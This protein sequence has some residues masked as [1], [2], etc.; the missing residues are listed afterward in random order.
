[1]K[2]RILVIGTVGVDLQMGFDFLPGG[3]Q[4]VLGTRFRFLPGGKG[5]VTSVA[6]SRLGDESLICTRVGRDMNASR[7]RTVFSEEGIDDRFLISDREHGT[8]LTVLMTDS[9]GAQRA[10]VYPGANSFLDRDNVESA[11]TSYPDAVLLQF[12]MPEEVVLASVEYAARQQVPILIDPVPVRKDFP[13][14][15]LGKVTFFTPNENETFLYTGIAPEGPEKCL[16]ACQGL[17]SFVAAEYYV[18]KLG[19]SGSFVYDGT[20]YDV[21]PSYDVVPR[22]GSGAGDSFNAALLSEYLRTGNIHRAASFANLAAALTVSSPGL[23]PSLPTRADV[24]AFADKLGVT[25]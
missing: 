25:L 10:V 14:S 18:L 12:E 16:R 20:Y 6:V 11:F 1:M 2:K 19:S 3:G 23:I 21:I 4:T 15:S 7:L 22:D 17:K 9:T 13:F 5:T 24:E 8:G